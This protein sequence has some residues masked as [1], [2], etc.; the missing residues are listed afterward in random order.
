[1]FIFILLIRSTH[2]FLKIKQFILSQDIF[3]FLYRKHKLRE[4]K[5][6]ILLIFYFISTVNQLCFPQ[7]TLD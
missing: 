7:T 2:E 3:N 4:G 1:M 5:Y 6:V